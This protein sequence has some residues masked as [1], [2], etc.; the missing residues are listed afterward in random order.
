MPLSVILLASAV[1]ALTAGLSIGLIP[2][3]IDDWR[4]GNKVDALHK[5][6]FLLFILTAI[7]A[8]ILAAMGL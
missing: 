4:I 5:T 2:V 8:L 1:G 7:T 3:I 6:G